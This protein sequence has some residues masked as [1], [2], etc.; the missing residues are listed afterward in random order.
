MGGGGFSST[1]RVGTSAKIVTLR[2]MRVV[3]VYLLAWAH[4]ARVCKR[5]A[6]RERAPSASVEDERDEMRQKRER[7]WLMSS[8]YGG[9]S[10]SPFW[11]PRLRHSA[12]S[13]DFLGNLIIIII[14]IKQLENFFVFYFFKW[15]FFIIYLKNSKHFHLLFPWKRKNM[16]IHRKQ[17]KKK[18]QKLKFFNESLKNNARQLNNGR[19]GGSQWGVSENE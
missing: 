1:R 7:R 19:E 3:V 6:P 18:A 8:N 13:N 2:V 14:F 5:L 16:S 17:H 15:L 10:L 9:L 12:K 4:L 11:S